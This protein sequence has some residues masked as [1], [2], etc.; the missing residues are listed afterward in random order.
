MNDNRE[1]ARLQ[2]EALRAEIDAGL[3]RI[4]KQGGGIED[5]AAQLVKI[6]VVLSLAAVGPTETLRGI[7]S[8]F[9][10]LCA[11]YPNEAATAEALRD[12]P[13]VDGSA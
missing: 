10:Q 8:Q 4:E 3:N 12:F 13:A 7:F 1:T 2:F 11:I 5:V 9:Q 6:G